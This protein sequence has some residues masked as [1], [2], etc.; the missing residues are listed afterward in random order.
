MPPISL[1]RQSPRV[2]VVGAGL[3]GLN[4]AFFLKQA[5]CDVQIYEASDRVGGRVLTDVSGL[6]PGLVSELGGEFIDSSHVDMLALAEYL[7]LPLLDIQRLSETAMSD[8]YFIRGQ[9]YSEG[10]VVRAFADVA[11]Q[12]AADIARLPDNINH[13]SQNDTAIA[14]DRLSVAEYLDRL[15]VSGWFRELIDVAYLT[16]YGL[17]TGEQSSLNL[18]TLIGTDVKSGFAVF[19][20]SDQRFKVI[21]GN[22]QITQAL[23]RKLESCINLENRLVRMRR[24]DHDV[25]LTLDVTGSAHEVRVDGV[26]LALPFTLLRQVDL[27]DTFPPAKRRAIDELG[28]GQGAK[29]LLGTHS[30]L[31]R[32]DGFGGDLYS[33]LP[34]QTGWDSSRLRQGELGVYTFFLGGNAGRKLGEGTA[35]A[36]ADAMAAHLNAVFPGVAAQ[37]TGTIRRVHWPSKPF[38]LGAYS[39]YRPGQWTSVAGIEGENVGSICFAGEHCSPDFQGFMNGAAESGRRATWTLLKSLGLAT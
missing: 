21:G 26:V 16:E 37:R 23:A 19:G 22:E 7:E 14:L 11:P 4:S 17:E 24:N 30:R 27:G 20:E 34:F 12:F 28:Y 3:A 38:S 6:Q 10:D 33:D 29:L 36:H 13:W 18:L 9:H 32:D 8:A 5:G 39:C 25:S 31:W 15:G 35:E 1:D 2:A